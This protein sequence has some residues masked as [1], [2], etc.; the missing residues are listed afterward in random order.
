MQVAKFMRSKPI[1]YFIIFLIL[2]YTLLV[3]VYLA[4]D[5]VIEESAQAVLALQ[6]FELVLLFIF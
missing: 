4:I 3:V 5:T 1:D 2:L 6:I